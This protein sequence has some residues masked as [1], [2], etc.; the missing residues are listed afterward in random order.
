MASLSPSQLRMRERVE[1]LIR[2]A[3]PALDLLLAVGDRVSRIVEREDGEYHPPRVSHEPASKG[4]GQSASN[5]TTR[6][7]RA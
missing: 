6:S 7:G 3:A 2:L 5:P 1:G 4:S